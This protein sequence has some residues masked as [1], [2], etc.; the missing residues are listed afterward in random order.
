MRAAVA[1][2][3]GVLVLASPAMALTE[4]KPSASDP[5]MQT[6]AYVDGG[7]IALHLAVGK[8]FTVRFSPGLT[9][10]LALSSNDKKVLDPKVIGDQVVLLKPKQPIGK[11]PLVVMARDKDGNA[12]VYTFEVDASVAGDD[13]QPFGLVVTDPAAERA[14]K[15]AAWRASEAARKEREAQAML[16]APPSKQALNTDYSASGNASFLG[17]RR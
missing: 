13:S 8:L 7:V 1:A 16:Q 5:R 17:A 6:A 3:L 4:P 11:E 9:G 14:A 10:M 2:A 15:I 12:K